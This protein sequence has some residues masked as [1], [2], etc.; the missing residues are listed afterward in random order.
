MTDEEIETV[1][2]KVAVKMG[3]RNLINKYTGE[4]YNVNKLVRDTTIKN[5]TCLILI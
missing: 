2:N 1:V 5:G 3:D 4:V